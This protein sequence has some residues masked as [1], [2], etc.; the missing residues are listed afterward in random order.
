MNKTCYMCDAIATSA[1]HVP[2]KCLFPESKDLP[3]GGDLRKK[4]ITVPSCPTHNTSKS[5]DDEYLFHSLSF[6]VAGNKIANNQVATKIQRAIKRKPKLINELNL[7]TK[8]LLIQD[9][10]SGKWFPGQTL[11]VDYERIESCIDKIARGIYFHHFKDKWLDDISINIHFM[12]NIDPENKRYNENLARMDSMT[13]NYL[14]QSPTF[15]ENQD[16]FNYKLREVTEGIVMGLSFY[17]DNRVTLLINKT[18]DKA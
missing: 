4:L 11:N 5:N 8:Q 2:P 13:Q 9:M 3:D 14:A 16:V 10:L 18:T 6:S 1:E 12:L 15:G 17:G 7:E